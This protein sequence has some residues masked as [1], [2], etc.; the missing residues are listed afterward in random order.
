MFD[1]LKLMFKRTRKRHECN[2]EELGKNSYKRKCTTCGKE[3]WLFE[4]R[5]PDVGEAKYEWRDM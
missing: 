4:N 5:Y 2:Y 1:L 3:Q